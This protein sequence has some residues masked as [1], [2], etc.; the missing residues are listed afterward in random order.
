MKLVSE[1]V[2]AYRVVGKSYPRADVRDKVTG[3]ALYL[4]DLRLT[5]MLYGKVLRSPHS[6]ARLVRVDTSRARAL[7]GVRAVITGAD[8]PFVHGESIWDEPFL[9]R[10]KVRYKGEAVAAVAAVDEETAEDALALIT[11]DYEPLPAVLDLAG[12][13]KP[14]AILVHERLDTYRCELG[15]TP[16]PGSNVCNHFQLARGDVAAGMAEADYL[17]EDTF[18]TPMQQHCSIEPHIAVCRVSNDDEM[19]LWLHNDSPYRCRKEIANA[20]KIPLKDVRVITAP[21]I[22]GNFGGKGGLKAEAPAIALAWTL[23]NRPIRIVYTREEE[24]CAALGRHPSLIRMKTG[25]KRDGTIVARRAEVYLDT[26][27]YAEKGPTVAVFAGVSAAGPYKI[28]HVKVD[29]YCVYTNKCVAGAMR[30]YG[31]PQAAWAYESQMDIIAARLGMDPLEIRLK[32]VYEEGDEHITGQDSV[33]QNLKEC[34]QAVAA[35]MEWGKPLGKNR[36][37][38]IACMER[39]VKTPFGSAAYVQVNED[40]TVDVI[41]STTEVGQGSET[42]LRQIAAEELGVPLESVAKAAPDTA[43]TPFDASTTSSRSTFHMG[44]AVK[45]AAADARAQLLTL[46]A[47]L[48]DAGPSDLTIRDGHVSVQGDAS[49]TLSIAQVLRQ[50]YGPSGT[51][52][53]RGYY[54]PTMPKRSAEYYSRYMVYWLLGANGAEVEVDT[55]T[56]QVKVLKLWGAYDTGKAIHPVNCEGQIQGGAATGL[57]FAMG[58]EVIFQDG[59]VMNPTFLAYKTPVA[60]DVPEIVPIL[61]ERPHPWG[62]YGAKGLGETTNVPVPPAI[63]NAIF[64][65]VGVRIKD[66]PITPDKVLDALKKREREVRHDAP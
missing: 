65:A 64:D 13:V 7:P 1:G 23:R 37:R 14:G 2:D 19:T 61:V 48:L 21:A 51:V 5:G 8:F 60:P 39:A 52:L 32:Q 20:L 44:N 49:K 28:P 11:V 24:F 46:A 30:G 40:G 18:T 58:E 16:I 3:S 63:A 4:E 25:V 17:F 10:D 47:P 57:G 36:G 54:I 55:T 53:G 42:V 50:H 45:T 35:R 56:G 59:E 62:P 41:S 12:A 9:A 66:L 26:G 29:A 43:F 34:L 27:A 33:S 38:G 15:I 22:G 31:G 6:H